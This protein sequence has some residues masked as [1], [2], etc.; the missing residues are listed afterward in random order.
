MRLSTRLHGMLDYLL[1]LALVAA[2]W[3]L[4]FAD[5]AGAAPPIV[6]GVALLAYSL[7]TDYELGALHRLQIPHHLWLDALVGLALA[8]SPWVLGFDQEVW[9]PHVLAGVVLVV[10]AALTPTVPGYE[11]RRAPEVG[12][13]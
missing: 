1:A 9:A 5:G 2:P 8:I 11:R 13:G 4:G 10:A 3:V 7:A 12:R 6:A